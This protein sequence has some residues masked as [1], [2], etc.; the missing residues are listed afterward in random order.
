[1]VL[2]VAWISVLVLR[3][4]SKEA[5]AIV[6]LVYSGG[7]DFVLAATVLGRS[8]H[9]HATALP[10]VAL[11]TDGVPVHRHAELQASGWR[12]HPVNGI[13]SP[14][15]NHAS[16]LGYVYSKL[17]IFNL[18]EYERVVY[19]DADT[20]AM[21]NI[22]SLCTANATVSAVQRGVFFNAG[23]LVV[24][25]DAILH[26]ELV[27]HHASTPSYTGGDQG[28]LNTV[29][30]NFQRCTFYDPQTDRRALAEGEL[31]PYVQE[32][33]MTSALPQGTY[34]CLRLPARYNGD[35]AL[36]VA[37]GG[38]WALDPQR[39]RQLPAILHYTTG[40]MKPWHWWSYPVVADHWI[41]WQ[42]RASVEH[43]A[44]VR[45]TTA[46]LL[47]AFTVV[48]L[49]Y[50]E[51]TPPAI[52][53]GERA[54]PSVML[55]LL[56]YHCASAAS[57]LTAFF[58][59]AVYLVHQ[60]ANTVLFALYYLVMHECV[61]RYCLLPRLGEGCLESGAAHTYRPVVS[62]L[63]GLT[64]VAFFWP[65]ATVYV[66]CIVGFALAVAT[67]VYQTYFVTTLCAARSAYAVSLIE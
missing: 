52:S 11:V 57:L 9:F 64:L 46:A 41:W 66:H 24:T 34:S 28:Y 56:A 30:W 3:A 38:D 61:V 36:T 23:V 1:M 26:E 21:E 43:D 67:L 39:E 58:S 17:H 42:F 5:C 2:V 53:L 45:W 10:T 22:D 54:P 55:I 33:Q 32:L 47:F 27:R 48:A 40:A 35:V 65:G 29:F 31:R 63:V 18:V 20:L 13:A 19:L 49:V 7:S 37:R 8:L 16:R 6:T 51:R 60:L 59:S 62:L 44:S 14:F 50:F 4:E 25:P 15:A 12:V